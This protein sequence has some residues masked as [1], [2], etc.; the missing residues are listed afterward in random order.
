[1]RYYAHSLK[2]SPVDTWQPL[3][4][5]LIGTAEL[6]ARFASEFGCGQWGYLKYNVN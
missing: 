4:K 1:M 5:H 2:E 3:D 6:A